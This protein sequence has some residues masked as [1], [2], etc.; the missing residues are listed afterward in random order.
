MSNFNIADVTDFLTPAS[1]F[2][3]EDGRE[4]RVLFLTNTALPEKLKSKFPPQVVYADENDNVLSCG[5]EKFLSIRKFF[6]VDPELEQRLNNLLAASSGDDEDVLDLMADGGSGDDEL[7]VSDG[8]QEGDD[9]DLDLSA[10]EAE[11][12]ITSS[13]T[14]DL[15]SIDTKTQVVTFS[16]RNPELPAVVDPEALTAAVVSYQQQPSADLLATQHVLFIQAEAGI[17]AQ[18]LGAAFSPAN[19]NTNQT[20]EFA[21]DADGSGVMQAVNWDTFIGVYPCVFYGQRMF[22]VLFSVANLPAD[23][24]AII[25]GIAEEVAEEVAAEVLNAIDAVP[26]VAQVDSQPAAPAPAPQASQT[27]QVK[28]AAAPNTAMAAAMAAAAGAQ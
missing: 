6:N 21:V 2:T 16:V 11:A 19:E 10:L 4:A 1:V 17:N 13:Q 23:H 12:G 26:V 24:S 3:R 18:T 5:I 7:E 27:I 28:M 22:Q 14:R 15:D 9:D 20:F 8:G 25:E